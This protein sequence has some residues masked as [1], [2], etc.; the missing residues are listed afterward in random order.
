MVATVITYRQCDVTVVDIH[1]SKI[2]YQHVMWPFMDLS[3]NFCRHEF[4][5]PSVH[6]SK[7]LHFCLIY[8]SWKVHS[9]N[10]FFSGRP[11]NRCCLHSY[12]WWGTQTPIFLL[13]AFHISSRSKCFLKR[14]WVAPIFKKNMLKS[15]W[16]TFDQ[17]FT[18]IYRDTVCVNVQICILTYDISYIHLKLASKLV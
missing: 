6:T 2:G 14:K 10:V 13:F 9:G 3:K 1:N 11:M 5:I 8:V 4:T 7:L 12:I 16:M 17:H 18:L 15:T